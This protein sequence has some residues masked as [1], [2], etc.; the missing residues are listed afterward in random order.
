MIVSLEAILLST[1]IMMSQRRHGEVDRA[2]AEHDYKV[3]EETLRHLL[4]VAK[5]LDV[6]IE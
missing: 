2:Q 5:K 3:N 1:I 6:D 4:A